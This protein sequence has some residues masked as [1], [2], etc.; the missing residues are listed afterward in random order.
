MESEL[1]VGDYEEIPQKHSR[2][3]IMTIVDLLPSKR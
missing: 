2:F 1:D 3:E